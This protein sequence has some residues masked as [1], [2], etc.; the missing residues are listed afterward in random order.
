MFACTFSNFREVHS[1]LHAHSSTHDLALIAYKM[2]E[3]GVQ[4][5]ELVLILLTSAFVGYISYRG[6][7][8]RRFTWSDSRIER[9][10]IRRRDRVELVIV[11]SSTGDGQSHQAS[12]DHID[13]IVDGVMVVA[14]LHSYGQETNCSERWIV[15]R[16]FQLVCRYL[17]QDESIEGDIAIESSDDVVAISVR[18]WK[19]SKSNGRSAMSIGI[20]SDVQPVSAPSF[21]ITK[22]L[23]QTIDE[24]FNVTLCIV[25]FVCSDFI[26]CWR[27]PSEI[28]RGAANEL[29]PT[30]FFG[31]GE[32]GCAQLL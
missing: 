26:P 5:L 27:Q 31:V 19:C 20:A 12:S 13:L 30:Y 11:A 15:V 1:N 14:K 6:Q 22:R 21:A 25:A 28:K 17:L 9:V 24:P 23:E 8:I 32:S 16:K 18:E 10:V 3:L 2:L 29:V 4:F 7:L